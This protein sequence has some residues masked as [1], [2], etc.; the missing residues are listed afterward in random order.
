MRVQVAR[1]SSRVPESRWER[2]SSRGEGEGSPW[3]RARGAQPPPARTSA[4]PRAAAGT[5]APPGAAQEPGNSRGGRQ[6]RSV[7]RAS[8]A[9]PESG[10]GAGPARPR[11]TA[12]KAA[13]RE[14]SLKSY[15]H[16]RAHRGP[17]KQLASG[18]HPKYPDNGSPV[19]SALDLRRLGFSPRGHHDNLGIWGNHLLESLD[20]V[21][22]R[23]DFYQV[24]TTHRTP[25]PAC[26]PS[27]APEP[28][29]PA[30]LHG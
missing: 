8:R 30:P 16:G 17:F 15:L 22:T 2:R 26:P 24:K 10:P 12:E 13:G 18:P 14:T 9:R 11:V 25:R 27:P 23:C 5:R 20:D 28:L 6:V 4:E 19:L 21:R 1:H 3:A 7:R 29:P